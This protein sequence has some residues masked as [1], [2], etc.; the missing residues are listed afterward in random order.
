MGDF[1]P[2]LSHA[3]AQKTE[4]SMPE[5]PHIVQCYKYLCLASYQQSIVETK[6]I[7]LTEKQK[8]ETVQAVRQKTVLSEEIQID[9]SLKQHKRIQYKFS[10]NTKGRAF[11]SISNNPFS[12]CP[13]QSQ[14][15]PTQTQ[16]Y[17]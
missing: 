9:M 8:E 10:R 7:L 13:W 1:L 5:A 6:K 16:K 2:T 3:S 4:L 14:S 11:I 17:S 12:K 15:L